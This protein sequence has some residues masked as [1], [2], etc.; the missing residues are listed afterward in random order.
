MKK[1]KITETEIACIKGMIAENISAEDMSKQL[2]RSV[3]LI[4]KESKRI[5]EQAVRDQLIIKKTARGE[6]GIAAMTEAGSVRS[7]ENRQEAPPE[8]PQERKAWVHTIYDK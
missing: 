3:S 5:S 1:G 2:N 8:A 4:E 6:S 7:D